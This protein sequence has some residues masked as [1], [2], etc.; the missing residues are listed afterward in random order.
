M[1]E[2]TKFVAFYKRYEFEIIRDY[3]RLFEITNDYAKIVS[4]LRLQR[5]EV[6]I[7]PGT[8]NRETTHRVVSLFG[9]FVQKDSE[10]REKNAAVSAF[11]AAGGEQPAKLR[12]V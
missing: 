1:P 10:P 11:L 12:A 8:P 5:S 2:I 4:Q 3:G 9:W 6:R 7:L